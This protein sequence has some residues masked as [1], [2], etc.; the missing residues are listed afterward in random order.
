MAGRSFLSTDSHRPNAAGNGDSPLNL[1]P[2]PP[3]DFTEERIAGEQLREQQSHGAP[4]QNC[5]IYITHIPEEATEADILEV[6]NTSAVYQLRLLKL[7]KDL[8]WTTKSAI[9]EFTTFSGARRFIAQ[10][11][12]DNGYKIL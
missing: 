10:V 11:N 6:V 8:G 2:N 5:A 4:A 9:L 7:R 3:V 12:A 1:E